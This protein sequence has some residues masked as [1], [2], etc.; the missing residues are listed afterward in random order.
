M[1]LKELVEIVRE[2][3]L[4]GPTGSLDIPISVAGQEYEDDDNESFTPVVKFEF[5]AELRVVLVS[6]VQET[7]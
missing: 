2:H 7:G 4:I 1:T 3:E 5:G 6:G